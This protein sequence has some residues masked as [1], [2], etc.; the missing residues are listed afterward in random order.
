MKP[1]LARIV[2]EA[3]APTVLVSVFLLG[4]GAARDGWR[5]LLFGFIAA[6]FVAL[7]PFLGILIAAR[8]GKLTDHHV[9]D[10][11]QRL[12]VLI[13]SLGSAAIGFVGLL[14]TA[15]GMIVVGAV[16]AF[17]KLSVHNAVA[18]F[19]AVATVGS[20]GWAW[21][22]LLLLPLVI[23]WS[24]VVLKDHTVAQVIAGVPAGA[25]VAVPYIL[26]GV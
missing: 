4:S 2:T 14:S 25:L 9:G 20:F 26:A 19:V 23:G 22:P 21:A 10:R 3:F 13:G 1:S 17:W 24:R 15:L 7:G 11:K 6:I 16:N 5:G 8:S 18:A 12:P